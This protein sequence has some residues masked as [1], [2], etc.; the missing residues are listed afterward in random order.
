M[1]SSKNKR[2]A[3]NVYVTRGHNTVGGSSRLHV[4]VT[5]GTDQ[6]RRSF[7]EMLAHAK[8]IVGAK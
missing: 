3:T 7:H 2:L 5:N 4:R 6:D 8:F 1:A